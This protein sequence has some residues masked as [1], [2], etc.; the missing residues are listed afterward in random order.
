MS[1]CPLGVLFTWTA[2]DNAKFSKKKIPSDYVFVH[3]D[4]T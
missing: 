1:F 2:K 3:L 4:A